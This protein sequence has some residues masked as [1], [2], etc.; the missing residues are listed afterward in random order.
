[1]IVLD[2]I[3]VYIRDRESVSHARGSKSL[4]LMQILQLIDKAHGSKIESDYESAL[5]HIDCTV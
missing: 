5:R 4:C 1:M 2:M 3:L